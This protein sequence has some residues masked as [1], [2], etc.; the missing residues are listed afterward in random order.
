MQNDN[1]TTTEP[2]RF[3]QYLGRLSLAI[4]FSQRHERLA[5]YLSGLLLPGDRKS[6][7][8]M[9]AMMEPSRTRAQHQAMH[10][11]VAKSDWAEDAL[12]AEAYDYAIGPMTSHGPI[13]HWAIDDTGLPK[14][15]PHSV[16][17]ARQY[18]GA[19]G[20][21]DLCQVA[22]SLSLCNRF[23]SL[24]VGY[25][26]Y[27][28]K[29]WANDP[30]RREKTGIPE[31]MIFREKWKIAI[32][33]VDQ[34]LAKGK[35]R[36]TV[37]ADSAYGDATEFREALTAR[38][39]IYVVGAKSSV[40]IWPPGRQPLPPKPYGGRGQPPKCLRRD[41]DHQAVSALE[42][43][44]SLSAEAFQEVVW[45]NG[46]KGMMD[47]RFAAVRVRAAHRDYYRTEPRPE[48]WLLIE[49][50]LKEPEPTKYWL[51][52][53]P[54]T[55]PVSELVR[56][57]KERWH[58]ERD[59]QELKDELGLDHYEGRNW[60]GF[61]HHASLCIAAYAF[62]VAERSRF[63]P[64]SRIRSALDIQVP[65]VP[66][67]FR[68]RGAPEDRTAST[69]VHHN[70]APADRHPSRPSTAPL[71]DLPPPSRRGA[72]TNTRAS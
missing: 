65:A 58:I 53:L 10:H 56:Q 15:G 46:A 14:R 27:L 34:A 9:A 3:E 68:R 16:G 61:H 39:L 71:S 24:P 6:V 62:L 42:L 54:I 19:T 23:V 4:S 47:S 8:P 12:L 67:G 72:E 69:H 60:R 1:D 5:S 20:K 18:C 43:A 64:L 30:V 37:V 40:S 29:D 63:S 45:R 57:A 41:Q 13:E 70:S 26:L 66:P 36:G 33:L 28:P 21:T 38:H 55:T 35:P 22:V 31:E 7:E 17:T 2:E 32:D 51:S 11:F 44:K 25:R 49:W 50:P 52:T 48:E 59:Y